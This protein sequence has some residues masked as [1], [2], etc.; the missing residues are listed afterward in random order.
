M[1]EKSHDGDVADYM[2]HVADYK[3]IQNFLVCNNL[4]NCYFI[5]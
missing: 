4:N 3:T 2:L 1:G 5:L